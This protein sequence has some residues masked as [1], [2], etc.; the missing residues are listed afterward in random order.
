MG[1]IQC[2]GSVQAYH[3]ASYLSSNSRESLHVECCRLILDLYFCWTLNTKAN[4]GGYSLLNVFC[5]CRRLIYVRAFGP[6]TVTI[7]SIAILNIFKIYRAPASI[8]VVGSIPKVSHIITAKQAFHLKN[9]FVMQVSSLLLHLSPGLQLILYDLTHF[10][11]VHDPLVCSFAYPCAPH[12]H[13]I[14]TCVQAT[15]QKPS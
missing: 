8:K 11:I 1:D 3:T 10:C 14:H 12:L 13:L 9:S 6:L 7:L 5:K 2:E 4:L 15:H